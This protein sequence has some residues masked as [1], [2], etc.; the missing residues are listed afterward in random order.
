MKLLV[1]SIRNVLRNPLR[2]ILVVTL[3][4]MSLMFVAAMMS[5]S[6]NSQQELAAVQK[7]VGTSIAINYASNE[8]KSAQSND[9]SNGPAMVIGNSPNGPTPIP[10]SAV[11]NIK[12]VPG[13]TNVQVSLARPD[14][15]KALKGSPIT[16]PDGKQG[17]I[18]VMINGIPSDATNFTL[19]GGDTP[20]LVSGRGFR[21]SDA[22]ANVAMM[23]EAVAQA[24][25]LKV[26]STF[27][28][29]GATF[30]VIGLYKAASQFSASSIIIPLATMQQVFNIHG[31]DS[32][33]VNAANYAQVEPVAAKL[34]SMLGKAYD[35][36]TQSAQFKN[37][38]SALQVAQNSIQIALVVSFL[39]AAAVIIFA[40]LMLVRERTAEIAILKTIGASHLQVLRQFWT[41]IVALSTTAAVLA[42]LLLMT[43]G[44]FLSQKFDINASALFNANS[45]GPG[46]G[47]QPI[48]TFNGAGTTS[49]SAG[50]TA[51]NQLSNIHLASATLNAQTLLIIVGVGIGLA[52]LTSLI[53]TW[54]VS[55][56]KPAQVL[57]KANN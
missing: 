6:T 36:V 39:I 50:L 15:D 9:G 45:S 16:T 21:A 3:L 32:V 43:L 28:L 46:F 24:N 23:D 19:V 2:M 27:E 44:P 25:H 31:V 42:V 5:L 12:R 40:V 13:V 22:N 14:T 1:R 20:T 54:F 38:L 30:T 41:E 57:R 48:M 7:K 56:I 33:T 47:S 53:P 10:N 52:L 17:S 37:V 29:H 34:R 4:G 35:I 55:H 18:P 49:G 51:S 11:A 8:A 26:G